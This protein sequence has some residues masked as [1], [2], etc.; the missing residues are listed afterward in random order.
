MH[1]HAWYVFCLILKKN[2]NYMED[3]W[4]LKLQE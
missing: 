4:D 2:K 3:E 1:V